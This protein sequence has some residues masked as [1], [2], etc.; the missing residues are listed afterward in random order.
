MK[1][2][3]VLFLVLGL[4]TFANAQQNDNRFS[5]QIDGNTL[6][7]D[8]CLTNKTNYK[9]LKLINQSE[10]DFATIILELSL[11]NEVKKEFA[12]YKEFNE[13]ELKFW[14]LQNLAF[15]KASKLTFTFRQEIL[16]VQSFS[17]CLKKVEETSIGI[18]DTRGE[19]EPDYIK[20]PVFYAT[21]RNYMKTGDV[22]ETFGTER[23]SLRYGMCIVSIPHDHRVGHIESPSVWKLEFSEDPEKHVVLHK[24]YIYNKNS[25]FNKLKEGIQKSQKKSSFLFVHGYNTSFAEAAKRTAQISYDLKFD[26]EAVFYSWPSK[27]SVAEY[28]RDEANIEWAQHDLE[29]FLKDYILRSGA[30]EIYLV[31]H[32]MGNRGLTRAI[33]NVIKEHPDYKNKIKEIILAAPDIDADVFKRD[34][35]PKMIQ[36]VDKPITLYVSS[37]DLA[38]KA[39]KQVHGYARAGDPDDGLILLNGIETVDATGI[40]TSFLSHSYFADTSSIIA[41]IYDLIQSGKRALYRKSLQLISFS[42]KNYWKVVKK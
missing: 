37:D 24:I 16:T 12:N 36:T 23:S 35:A 5:L 17:V 30:E 31:A 33:V 32:S 25:F 7:L 26:G 40:D 9:N 6:S 20:L 28:T 19:A 15:T 34:I 10:Q 13:F 8:S 29:I 1:K 18:D 3:T 11:N 41:D 22:Y 14:L 2:I 39:S 21:D 42:N 4:I 38:L 27:E